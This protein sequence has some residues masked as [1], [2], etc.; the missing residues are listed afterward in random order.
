MFNFS[1]SIFEGGCRNK[2]N[3]SQRYANPL[4]TRFRLLYVFGFVHL[5]IA[6]SFTAINTLNAKLQLD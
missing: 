2:K 3:V 4:K 6:R 1:F 5:Y